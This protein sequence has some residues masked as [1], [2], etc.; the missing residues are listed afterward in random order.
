[1]NLILHR[2]NGKMIEDKVRTGE[3][4]RPE[5]VVRAAMISLLARETRGDFAPRELE[6]LLEEGKES[7][8]RYGTLDAKAALRRRRQCRTEI[9]NSRVTT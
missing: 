4:D 1:M 2:K 8:R 5:D 3:Y 9:S 7:N 6:R